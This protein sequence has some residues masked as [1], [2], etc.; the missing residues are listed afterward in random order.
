MK[1][2]TILL[3]LLLAS[4]AMVA[5]GCGGS[6]DDSGPTKEEYIAEADKMC[7]ESNAEIIKIGKELGT[8]PSDKETVEAVK[9][10]LLPELESRAKELEAL[11]RP[12]GDEDELE[13]YYQ[14]LDDGLS[15]V[16]DD[17]EGAVASDDN[18][19]E[20]SDKAAKEY[21]FKVCGAS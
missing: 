11:E 21:G 7:E 4:M 6:D 12:S 18:P 1:K 16:A 8:N 2:L 3:T 17:P 19:F 10:D 14:D 15:T 13:A 20:A 5:V 9:S